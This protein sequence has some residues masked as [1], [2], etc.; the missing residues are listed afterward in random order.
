T[1]SPYVLPVLT[2]DSAL[3]LLRL[4]VPEVVEK[5]LKPCRELVR[6]LEYLP[7]A[8]HVAG[9]LLKTEAKMGWGVS[10]LVKEIQEGALLISKAAPLDRTE[11]NR[12]PTVTA[13]LKKS[14]DMLDE[15]TREGFARL[16]AFAP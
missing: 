9:N 6:S 2:E 10:E 12:I 14:T 3:K 15:A 5:Y 4:L 8:L 13:L 11:E 1:A 16:G 7:L